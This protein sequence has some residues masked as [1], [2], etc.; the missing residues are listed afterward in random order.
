MHDFLTHV[1]NPFL[2]GD[3]RWC[4]LF[5]LL[6][7]LGRWCLKFFM[8]SSASHTLIFKRTISVPFK[9]N[10]KLTQHCKS[11]ICAQSVSRVQLCD[12]MDCIP[13]ESSVHGVLQARI[14]EWVVISYSTRSSWPRDW[15]H[16]SCIGRQI[17]YHF[18]TSKIIKNQLYFNKKIISKVNEALVYYYSQYSIWYEFISWTTVI[19]KP[20]KVC[21][22]WGHTPAIGQFRSAEHHR[23]AV[24]P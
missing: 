19:K 5:P 23:S 2:R 24:F 20:K 4:L 7:C 17:L 3:E 14:L 22:C 18:A 21:E 10:L 13:P 15:T 6:F 1:L 16:I 12:L 11:T 8:H 9:L